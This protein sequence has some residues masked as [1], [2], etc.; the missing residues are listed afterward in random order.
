M[1]IRTLVTGIGG[2]IGQSIGKIILSEQKRF[3]LPVGTD[4]NN[5]HSGIFYFKN[6][7]SISPVNSSE[8]MHEI[9][10]IV[11][12]YKI[13]VIVPTSEA[14]IREFHKRPLPFKVPILMA[15]SLALSVGLDKM[16]T[17]EFFKS[18]QLPYPE[19][20]I[21]RD[22]KRF[23]NPLII[24]SRTSSGSKE[25]HRILNQKDLDYFG[26]KFPDFIAQELLESKDEYTCG[27]FRDGK[28]EA[29]CIIYKRKL[30]GGFSWSGELV[31]NEE[32]D[33]LCKL[34]AEKLNLEGSINIQLKL[35][36]GVPMVFEINP[37]FSSTV[38]FRHLMGF[39]DFIW[40][41]HHL[42]KIKDSFE[43]TPLNNAH[44]YRGTTE[45]ILKK[46]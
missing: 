36:D 37:R 45:Y 2:D 10:S 17:I 38:L 27:V 23:E 9:N 32:I 40:S 15:N 4:L 19:T 1:K 24:K 7:H 34:I 46:N 12:K 25:I 35:K 33:H 14:E 43:Y 22:I 20:K 13:D 6:H 18:N 26:E 29:Q 39:K 8:Y 44:F 5:H 28:S 21:L 3:A 42:F 11:D 16:N 41:I 30:L 31:R